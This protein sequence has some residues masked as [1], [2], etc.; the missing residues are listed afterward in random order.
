MIIRRA[1]RRYIEPSLRA[2]AS[3]DLTQD[4]RIILMK[5]V[6]IDKDS[7][8]NAMSDL[9]D[10]F[11]MLNQEIRQK[12]EM[13]NLDYPRE[14]AIEQN[15]AFLIYSLIRLL[16]PDKVVETGVA[17]GHSTFFILNAIL[18]N[19]KGKLYSIDIDY[20]V[21][22]LVDEQLKANWRLYVL[23]RANSRELNKYLSTIAPVDIFIHDSNHMY[24]W[25]IME[26]R[27]FLRHINDY[28]LIL[29]DDVDYSLAFIDFCN[30]N[31]L[32]PL[33]L[34]DHR[35]IFGVVKV[36][37]H[38][39]SLR[40]WRLPPPLAGPGL[41]D[42]CA[43]GAA[44]AGGPVPAGSPGSSGHWPLLPPSGRGTRRSRGALSRVEF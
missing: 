26:Y 33:F 36:A 1:F 13:L 19:G 35:K 17:N 42:A 9:G 31:E 41:V 2:F 43:P 21:G 37:A 7:L 39:R 11:L 22:I 3:Y 18:K 15:S 16:K 14:F 5:I 30:E 28:G 40:T 27:T 20:N 38:H 25:Q 23:P 24:Y 4:P 8:L 32:K 12:Y 44:A 34:Y 10:E 6:D 29:S